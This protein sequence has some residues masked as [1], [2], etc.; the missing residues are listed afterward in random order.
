MEARAQTAFC[1]ILIGPTPA[2]GGSGKSPVGGVCG[3]T[4]SRSLGQVSQQE[5]ES[6]LPGLPTMVA[7]APLCHS[8]VLQGKFPHQ[9]LVFVT[10]PY[11]CEGT[12]TQILLLLEIRTAMPQG[13]HA[14]SPP[15]LLGW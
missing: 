6:L 9:L 14:H 2:A 7:V 3:S 5:G 13:Q 15:L 12:G 1:Y 8:R 11:L 10:V 4:H